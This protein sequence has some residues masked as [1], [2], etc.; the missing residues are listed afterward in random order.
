MHRVLF[1]TLS[2][3]S[4]R[5]YRRFTTTLRQLPQF[6]PKQQQQQQFIGSN[7]QFQQYQHS[8]NARAM[9]SNV[10][11]THYEVHCNAESYDNGYFYEPGAYMENLV[12][13]VKDRMQL[14]RQQQDAAQEEHKDGANPVF[15]QQRQRQ[16][17]CILDIGGGTGTFAQALM[18]NDD[19]SSRVVVVEPFLDPKVVSETQTETPAVSFVKAPAEDFL[20]PLTKD[21]WRT[22][23]LPDDLNNN[24]DGS[25]G[26]GG[27]YDQILLKE[28][29]HHFPEEDRVGIF[30][31]MRE[32]LRTTTLVENNTHQSPMPSMLII[33]RPQKDIDY[34]MWDKAREVWEDNQPGIETIEEDL[35]S[36]GYTH[37]QSS[38]VPIECSI[39]LSR[40]QSMVK[41]RC[42]ST[43]SNFTDEELE[44]AC[45]SIAEN[46]E[47]DPRNTLSSGGGDGENKEHEPIL[48]FEDRLIFLTAS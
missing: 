42:W 39:S 32:G 10:V 21:C 41:S 23:L 37:L 25:G 2:S 4:L 44:D 30:R 34:P 15:Q 3:P 6:L 45:N 47:K 19:T 40:W 16:S 35:K 11:A 12:A 20:V 9:S 5:R 24:N 13:L 43:F 28:V 18:K 29:V 31:G 36:A 22:Q 1:S 27:G 26:G 17:R 38:M 7:R 33:T 8:T 14:V 48:R 46:V